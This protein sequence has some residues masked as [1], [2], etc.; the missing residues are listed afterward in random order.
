MCGLCGAFGGSDHWSAGTGA[1]SGTP[2]LERR[3]RAAL[4]NEVLKLY[5][6]TLDEWAGRFTLRSRTGKMGMVEHFGAIWPEAEKLIGRPCDPLDP[7]VIEQLE[8]S[9]R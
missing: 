3:A 7:V 8:A 5:G 6:L 4:A 9:R 1:P 2:T